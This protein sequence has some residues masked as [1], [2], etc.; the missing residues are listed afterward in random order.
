[1]KGLVF[2]KGIHCGSEWLK[3]KAKTKG[4]LHNKGK[5]KYVSKYGRKVGYSCCVE[6]KDILFVARSLAD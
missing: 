6:K 5:N 3:E 1:L 2:S 4:R